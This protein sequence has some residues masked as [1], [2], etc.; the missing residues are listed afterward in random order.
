M[1]KEAIDQAVKALKE[2][3]IILF[4]SDTTW[5]IGCDATS[6][7]SVENIK[8]LKGQNAVKNLIVL[9]ADDA[10][11]NRF[12]KDIPPIAWDLIDAA[13]QPLTI[14]YPEGR[15]LANGVISADGSVAIRMVK[16]EFCTQLIRRF[17]K[18]IVFTSANFTDDPTPL[19]YAEISA[20]FKTKVD[21]EVE[22][23]RQKDQTGKPSSIVKLSM[24]GEIQLIR[25]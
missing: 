24:N 13:D 14:V 6:Q 23:P 25:K 8:Q 4:P 3:K 2:K 18:P 19:S 21:Y 10:M 11:L 12:S 22:L 7:E 20:N 5:G 17:R 15:N 1:M 9:I 16:D